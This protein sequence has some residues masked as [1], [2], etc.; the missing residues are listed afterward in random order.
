[1]IER[2]GET[3]EKK[4]KKRSG[5][6]DNLSVLIMYGGQSAGVAPVGMNPPSANL[7]PSTKHLS[8][9]HHQHQQMFNNNNNT[10][11]APQLSSKMYRLQSDLLPA[12]DRSP[13][14]KGPTQAPSPTIQTLKAQQQ[15]QQADITRASSMPS[16]RTIGEEGFPVL[17][18]FVGDGMI[19]RAHGSIG[20][21]DD[22][23]LSGDF[24]MDRLEKHMPTSSVGNPSKSIPPT[25]TGT[26]ASA[27]VRTQ[28]QPSHANRTKARPQHQVNMRRSHSY[29][30]VDP[31]IAPMSLEQM[32]KKPVKQ[33]QRSQ[34]SS[35]RQ[36]PDPR[37]LARSQNP[38]DNPFIT[39]RSTS[40][41]S[42]GAGVAGGNRVR[43][44]RMSDSACI[45]R[46]MRQRNFPASFFKEPINKTNSFTQG[47]TVDPIWTR[48]IPMSPRRNNMGQS[49][50]MAV[51]QHADVE[52][53]F[54][55]FDVVGLK[56]K[57]KHAHAHAGIKGHTHG[58]RVAREGMRKAQVGFEAGG[59]ASHPH[60]PMHSASME[61]DSVKK[62]SFTADSNSVNDLL[63]QLQQD[64]S[65]RA[66]TPNVNVPLMHPSLINRSKWLEGGASGLMH[67]ADNFNGKTMATG[68]MGAHD[69]AAIADERMMQPTMMDAD[70][71]QWTMTAHPKDPFL[72]SADFNDTLLN[73]DSLFLDDSGR[74]Q[75]SSMLRAERQLE[76][77]EL[78]NTLS[79]IVASFG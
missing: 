31:S 57:D 19:N 72:N 48:G 21:L 17:D 35:S 64:A 26:D 75:Y 38:H 73:N 37:I 30:S 58:A 50:G 74:D 13:S 67:V 70:P 27:S 63:A 8:P 69:R 14:P 23:A 61:M 7:F 39:Q 20:A 65:S 12:L 40:P 43:P 33:R 2:E 5:A 55:L 62:A 15:Q 36:H 60:L 16:L 51:T 52:Q 41:P 68:D 45:A 66:S 3:K 32:G 79:K 28:Q 54:K 78:T 18:T 46:P 24:N 49:T 76:G 11:D 53:L 34:S 10:D 59:D 42:A 4:N 6:K 77:Q 25:A 22:D 9:R 47:P 56:D 44:R 29:T 1:M 71:D